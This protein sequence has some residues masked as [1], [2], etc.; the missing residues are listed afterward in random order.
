MQDRA[1]P[2]LHRTAGGGLARGE[3]AQQALVGWD[4]FPWDQPEAARG[5]CRPTGN[6]L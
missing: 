1:R 4:R 5:S 3:T 6:R 2:V